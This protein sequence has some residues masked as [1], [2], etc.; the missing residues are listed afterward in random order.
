MLVG[1][2]GYPRTGK[3]ALAERLVRDHGFQRLAFGD[4]VK[5]ALLQIDPF[6]R[7][8]LEFLETCKAQNAHETREKLQNVGQFI[9]EMNPSYWVDWVKARLEV[10]APGSKVVITDIRYPNE[11]HM[12][13]EFS[14]T[15]VGINRPGCQAVNDHVSER[16]TG[17]L[18]LVA[19]HSLINDGP[20][21]TLVTDL[22]E[23][24]P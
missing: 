3:D 6:Y 8:S 20:L 2:V 1:L 15:I 12:V 23:V 4:A 16:N 10:M 5:N 22:L 24:L 18:L 13:Q 19:D 21:D 14:G 9:R 11:F 7:G 17:D